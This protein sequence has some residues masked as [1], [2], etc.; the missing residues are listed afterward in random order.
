MPGSVLAGGLADVSL[1]YGIANEV[2]STSRES[3]KRSMA[4]IRPMVPTWMTSSSR[5]SPLFRYLFAA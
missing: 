2:N 5:P 4:L 1:M 3:S